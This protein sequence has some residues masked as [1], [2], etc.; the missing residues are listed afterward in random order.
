MLPLLPRRIYEH[1]RIS[2][3][4]VFKLRD[5]VDDFVHVFA[6]VFHIR[7]KD[8]ECFGEKVAEVN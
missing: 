6:S 1:V 2:H 5:S 4:C 8:T 7:C 3:S